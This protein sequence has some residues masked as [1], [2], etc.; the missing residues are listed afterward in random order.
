MQIKA[1]PSTTSG[2]TIE[3][4][5]VPVM[6]IE[7]A[8]PG[9]VALALSGPDAGRPTHLEPQEELR[10]HRRYANSGTIA[11]MGDR[12]TEKAYD[13]GR[14]DYGSVVAVDERGW[15]TVEWDGPTAT[16]AYKPSQ[17]HIS[18]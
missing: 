15:A 8:G 10:D 18:D 11:Q 13:D 16:G 5:G 3:V 2:L 12:V 17:L 9:Y 4:D 14:D 7:R 1:N 6:T